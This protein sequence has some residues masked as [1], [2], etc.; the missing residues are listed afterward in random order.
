MGYCP[1][2]LHV[3][4]PFSVAQISSRLLLG[5]RRSGGGQTR[6]PTCRQPYYGALNLLS[7][8]L[9][10][11]DGKPPIV[12]DERVVGI[13]AH[14]LIEVLDPP[15]VL[16]Q[17]DAGDALLQETRSVRVLRYARSEDTGTESGGE[18]LEKTET[19]GYEHG[20]QSVR[21]LELGPNVADVIQDGVGTE[22]EFVGDL[23]FMKRIGH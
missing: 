16:A 20:L 17:L 7:V 1:Q 18:K 12:A 15:A 14:E 11:F 3:C 9:R 21:C 2:R 19:L 13:Q 22:V 4:G 5:W 10:P 8:G 23:S 6:C